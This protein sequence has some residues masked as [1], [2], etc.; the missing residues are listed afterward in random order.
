MQSTSDLISNTQKWLWNAG[1]FT[2]AWCH[3]QAIWWVPPKFCSWTEQLDLGRLVDQI[4]E[5][6]VV[7]V[8]LPADHDLELL[9]QDVELDLV[10]Q[11]AEFEFAEHPAELGAGYSAIVDAIVILEEWVELYAAL[12]NLRGRVEYKFWK[13]VMIFDYE[14]NINNHD[15]TIL[16]VHYK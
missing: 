2:V 8:V 15:Q 11:G 13:I 10:D 16:K 9:P 3:Q 7:D 5:G 1:K 4:A 12:V 14:L 6:A